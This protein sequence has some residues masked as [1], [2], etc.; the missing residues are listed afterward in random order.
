MPTNISYS[1]HR[2]HDEHAV[3]RESVDEV[4]GEI[5]RARSQDEEWI[6]LHEAPSGDAVGVRHATIKLVREASDAEG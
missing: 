5:N 2:A 4:V 3:V 6:V 1:A